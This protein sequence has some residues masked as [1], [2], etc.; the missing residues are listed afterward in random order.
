MR[1]WMTKERM[2]GGKER[3]K[4]EEDDVLSKDG[5]VRASKLICF[6]TFRSNI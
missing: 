6:P 3:N 5:H 1:R 2:G 4:I